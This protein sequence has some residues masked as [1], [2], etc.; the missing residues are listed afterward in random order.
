MSVVITVVCESLIWFLYDVHDASV[1]SMMW[2]VLPY[3]PF[4]SAVMLIL[5]WLLD[6]QKQHEK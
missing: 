5:I 2:M 4:I 1:Y 3:M 6:K